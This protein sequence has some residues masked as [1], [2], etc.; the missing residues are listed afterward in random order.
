MRPGALSCGKIRSRLAERHKRRMV[1]VRTC[2]MKTFRIASF[3]ATLPLAGCCLS[4]VSCNAPLPTAAANLD[5]LGEPL[6]EHSVR[7]K[8]RV[9]AGGNQHVRAADR[10]A[11]IDAQ[12]GEED[13][14]LQSADDQLKR[15][16]VIC[17]GCGAQGDGAL[18]DRSVVSRT[19]S[20]RHAY[21]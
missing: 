14:Q 13:A 5:G 2:A 18:E 16:L 8:H 6:A 12:L 17:R 20:R 21:E 1:L 9:Q 10:Q 3:L 4:G 7:P 11:P 15:T 19:T